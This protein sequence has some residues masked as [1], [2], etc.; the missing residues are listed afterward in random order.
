MYSSF[1]IDGDSSCGVLYGYTADSPQELIYAN[2][3][4]FHDTHNLPN[5]HCH[6][7]YTDILPQYQDPNLPY[8]HSQPHY[9]QEPVFSEQLSNF[10]N[11]QS[12]SHSSFLTPPVSP[13]P[14]IT[15]SL[16]TATPDYIAGV[17][18]Y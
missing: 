3:P 13:Q 4:N 17:K 8:N 10:P 12:G 16:N 9:H 6:T 18:I 11:S 15:P 14:A 5:T 2:S 1:Q 7:Q